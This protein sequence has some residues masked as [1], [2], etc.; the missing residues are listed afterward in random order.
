[1]AE[2]DML[3]IN[4][5]LKFTEFVLGEIDNAS[6]SMTV[7]ELR[8]AF[9]ERFGLPLSRRINQHFGILRLVPLMHIAEH[10]DFIRNIEISGKITIIRNAFA[11]NDFTC[12]ESG[13]IFNATR[14]NQQ[15]LEISYADFNL[16][17]HQVENQFYAWLDTQT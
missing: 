6:D 9:Q 5:D 11:H 14:P 12:N 1:M 7:G 15:P 3:A 17:I 13:Y 4:A 10:R 16:L 2:R 8:K